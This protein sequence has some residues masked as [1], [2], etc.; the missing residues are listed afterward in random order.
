V[1]FKKGFTIV[2]L[3]V[4]IAIIGLLGIMLTWQ[5]IGGRAEKKAELRSEDLY[6]AREA[7]MS[8]SRELKYAYSIQS[9]GDEQ[10]EYIKK[11]SGEKST[12]KFEDGVLKSIATENFDEKKIA[13]LDDFEL[14]L[15]GKKGNII[16]VSIS[17]GN[18]NL[19]TGILIRNKI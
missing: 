2:E 4:V 17:K 16:Q 9:V 3:L 6:N 7:M 19:K 15:G 8:I 13:E 12:L 10:I 5:V 1:N 18:V 14:N 11:E